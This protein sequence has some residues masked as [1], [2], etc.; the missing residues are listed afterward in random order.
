MTLFYAC[1]INN[2]IFL[3]CSLYTGLSMRLIETTPRGIQYFVFEHSKS[4]QKIQ[5]EFLDA[6][7]SLNPQNIVVFI[8]IFQ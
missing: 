6:V 2:I 1:L 7:E 3:R 4:Y 8:I 5:F